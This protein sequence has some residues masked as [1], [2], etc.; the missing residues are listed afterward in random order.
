MIVAVAY[1]FLLFT[2]LFYCAYLH[3][4]EDGY[5]SIEENVSEGDIHSSSLAIPASEDLES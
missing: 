4:P 2:G 1:I 3:E 5:E